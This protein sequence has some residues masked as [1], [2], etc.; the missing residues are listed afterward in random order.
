MHACQVLLKPPDETPGASVVLGPDIR[1]EAIQTQLPPADLRAMH[2]KLWL[3]LVL[4][5]VLFVLVVWR[6]SGLLLP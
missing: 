5:D 2:W 6:V 1:P 3:A 4:Y